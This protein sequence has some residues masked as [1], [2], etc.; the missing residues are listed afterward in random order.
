[1]KN[2]DKKFILNIFILIAIS[3]IIAS[4][5]TPLYSFNTIDHFESEG[6]TYEDIGFKWIFEYSIIFNRW[7]FTTENLTGIKYFIFGFIPFETLQWNKMN[8]NQLESTSYNFISE[9]VEPSSNILLIIAVLV[10]SIILFISFFYFCYKGIKFGVRK[11]TRYF[12]YAGVNACLINIISFL[13][14][15]FSLIVIESKNDWLKFT[16]FIKFEYGFIYMLI[17]IV[18][19]LIAFIIQYYFIDFTKDKTTVE[20]VLFEKYK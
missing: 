12:L 7:T 9:G 13:A 1:M 18:L 5:F 15:Y 17:S 6:Y 4:I 10:S 3:L 16:N 11:K 14:F 2:K 19:F 20:K 8:I